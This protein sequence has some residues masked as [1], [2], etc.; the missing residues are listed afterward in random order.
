MW[1][2]NT[3]LRCHVHMQA[4][5]HHPF[6]PLILVA[7]CQV[8]AENWPEEETTGSQFIQVVALL[9][10]APNER[11]V[12][13]V[14]KHL[15]YALFWKTLWGKGKKEAQKAIFNIPLRNSLKSNSNKN[16]R[17]HTEVNLYSKDAKEVFVWFGLVF[18]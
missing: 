13:D 8:Q 6:S 3:W 11:R 16:I 7:K 12:L 5:S 17:S 2:R 9:P 14:C 10:N 4:T 1:L 15:M 18:F